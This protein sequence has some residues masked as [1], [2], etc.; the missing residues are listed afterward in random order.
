M[1]LGGGPSKS[2]ELITV[3][4]RKF[5]TGGHDELYGSGKQ[6]S[7]SPILNSES[8]VFFLTGITPGKGTLWFYCVDQEEAEACSSEDNEKENRY[9]LF[10]PPPPPSSVLRE[11]RVPFTVLSPK[12]SPTLQTIASASDPRT[13][14]SPA[15]A[16][17]RLLVSLIAKQRQLP[18]ASEEA[19]VEVASELAAVLQL[20]ITAI[21]PGAGA[22]TGPAESGSASADT[23]AALVEAIQAAEDSSSVGSGSRNG[24]AIEA[25]SDRGGGGKQNVRWACHLARHSYFTA[26]VKIGGVSL[27]PQEEQTLVCEDFASWAYP[28]KGSP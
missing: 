4:Q 9:P 22:P 3:S 28:V 2:R 24:Y 12:A 14:Q 13:I 18:A 16:T 10:R 27:M 23:L 5:P 7:L 25:L 1:D 21:S 8:P 15:L 17:V 19:L 20:N 26:P 6:T 11:I